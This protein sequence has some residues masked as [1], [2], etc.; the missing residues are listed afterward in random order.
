MT[1]K[2]RDVTNSRQAAISVVSH[3]G[4]QMK[5]DSVQSRRSNATT[6]YDAKAYFGF[7]YLRTT[8]LTGMTVHHFV[9]HTKILN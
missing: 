6:F 9:T 8:E 4:H 7:K 1:L 3:F 5:Y 2:E